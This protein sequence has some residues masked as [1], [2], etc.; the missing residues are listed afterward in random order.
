MICIPDGG[1]RPFAPRY[2]DNEEIK[3]GPHS[4][5]GTLLYFVR[6]DVSSAV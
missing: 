6:S 1:E 3:A 2:F 4:E 5:M